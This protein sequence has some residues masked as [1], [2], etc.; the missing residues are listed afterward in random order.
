MLKESAK[1]DKEMMFARKL[2][3]KNIKIRNKVNS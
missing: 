1:V 3:K 2:S